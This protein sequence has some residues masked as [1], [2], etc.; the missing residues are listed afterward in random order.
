M[1]VKSIP[2]YSILLFGFILTVSGCTSLPSQISEETSPTGTSVRTT[3]GNEPSIAKQL[4]SVEH[5]LAS[6]EKKVG[7]SAETALKNRSKIDELKARME[8]FEIKGNAPDSKAVT[9][10]IAI[11]K[12]LS[13]EKLY[14][15][16]YKEFQSK[17][18][19]GAVK[20][21][22]G[23]LNSYPRSML[24]DNAMYWVGEAFYEQKDFPRAIE[25]LNKLVQEYPRANRAPYALFRLGTIYGQ[26]G[27]NPSA[28]ARFR[29]LMEKY[30]RSEPARLS[31]LYV[32]K[33]QGNEA[34]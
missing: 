34:K 18:Y 26:S 11:P 21:F 2:F 30:P 19:A 32:E 5:R 24:A 17:D 7:I 20:L 1:R 22:T 6:L 12:G 27:D 29:E 15:T 16:A 9:S 31:A 28:L 14:L 4:K 23:F 10:D 25:N 3:A 33:L 13:R 8:N